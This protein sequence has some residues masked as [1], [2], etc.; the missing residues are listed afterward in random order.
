MAQY[1][2]WMDATVRM[3]KE[4]SYG[5]VDMEYIIAPRVIRMP[6]SKGVFFARTSFFF[7]GAGCTVF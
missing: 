4:Q 5:V 1:N 7:M 3:Y 2:A 6:Q